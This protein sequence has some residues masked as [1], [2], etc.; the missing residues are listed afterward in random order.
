M[1]TWLATDRM[2]AAS[3]QTQTLSALLFLYKH[4]LKIE[5]PMLDATRAKRPKRLTV[6]LSRVV[7]ARP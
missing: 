1:L 2:V 5:L 4:V 7:L 6:V 3:T